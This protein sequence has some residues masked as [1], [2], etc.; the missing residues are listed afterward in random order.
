M[1]KHIDL[2]LEKVS[3]DIPDDI[4]D[5]LKKNTV[6]QEML[7]KFGKKAFL[8]PEELKFPVVDPTTGEPDVRLIY[9]AYVRAKQWSDK[10]PAYIKIA[11]KAKK[12]FI[13]NKGPEKLNIHIEESLSD[14]LTQ[15][16]LGEILSI[17]PKKKRVGVTSYLEPNPT[18]RCPNCGFTCALGS[19]T[20]C[21]TQPCPVCDSYMIDKISRIPVIKEDIT[22]KMA[23]NLD[24]I[25]E[26]PD[27]Q[28]GESFI[29]SKCKTI[30]LYEVRHKFENGKCPVCENNMIVMYE[31]DETIENE[32]RRLCP[33][34][35]STFEFHGATD[36]DTCPICESYVT[37]V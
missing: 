32:K 17:L 33:K 12:M 31:T 6:R 16:G 15:L 25:M 24:A 4:Q 27:G 21:S 35:K 13:Q 22:D 23:E 29:C 1:N 20:S 14:V 18:C 9:G 30:V 8:L 19:Y 28:E 7:S 34:C 5:K 36:P 11:E 3:S 26:T 2:L 37:V 10:K